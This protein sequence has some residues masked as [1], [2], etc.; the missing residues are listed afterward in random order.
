MWRE[1]CSKERINRR[2]RINALSVC[3]EKILFD[4][5]YQIVSANMRHAQQ[6][7]DSRG[8]TTSFIP[9]TKPIVAAPPNKF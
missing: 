4:K 9:I 3:S 2:T 5:S 1:P 7:R 8:G 6:I